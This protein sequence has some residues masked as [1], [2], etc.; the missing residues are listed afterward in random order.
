MIGK[1]VFLKKQLTKAGFEYKLNKGPTENTR[2]MLVETDNPTK[3][4]KLI[5]KANHEAAKTRMH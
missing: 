4:A 1:L 2:T 3:L 5:K